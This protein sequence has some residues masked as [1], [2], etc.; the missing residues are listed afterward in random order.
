M[1]KLAHFVKLC[2]STFIFNG[3]EWTIDRTGVLQEIF[4]SVYQTFIRRSSSEL[5]RSDL[6]RTH[7][8]GRIRHNVRHEISG[9]QIVKGSCRIAMR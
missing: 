8:G 2:R 4:D 7:R 3:L 6:L 1:R 9:W 5:K